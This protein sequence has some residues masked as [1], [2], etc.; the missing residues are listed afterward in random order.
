M[1]TST[2]A[3]QGGII[4]PILCT[5]TLD[6]LEALVINGRNKKQ[7]KLNTIRY[8]DDFIITGANP[9]ILLNEVKPEV[10]WFLAERGLTLSEEKTKLSHID[11]GFNFLGFNVRKFNQKLLI[12][13]QDGKVQSLLEKVRVFLD[14]HRGI[15][16][17]VMLLKLNSI[18]R[19]WAYAYRHSVA[20]SRMYY[21]DNRIYF[22]IRKWLQRECRSK[23]W[24]W[25]AKKCRKRIRGRVV[26]YARYN[27]AKGDIRIVERF[28][29][30]DLPIRYH[31]KVQGDATPYD[32][33]YTEYFANRKKNRKMAALRD[34]RHMKSSSFQKLAA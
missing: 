18:V 26:Y 11:D 20:K 1:D 5:M 13:P 3:P 7:G 23:T 33:S 16:F 30:G 8:A 27:S 34:R 14:Q 2:V 15:S 29:A 9:E 17:H 22:L 12:Q 19:G 25:I 21:A 24:A 6:G 31:T 28:L 4:S 32:V 10:E